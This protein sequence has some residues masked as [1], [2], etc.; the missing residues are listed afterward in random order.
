MS[1]AE[2]LAAAI[3]ALGTPGAWTTERTGERMLGMWPE[4]LARSMRKSAGQCALTGYALGDDAGEAGAG[5]APRYFK[6]ISV[7]AFGLTL[8]GP[9]QGPMSLRVRRR[10]ALCPAAVSGLFA[11]VAVIRMIRSGRAAGFVS[12]RPG[13]GPSGQVKARSSSSTGAPVRRL[14][15]VER[16]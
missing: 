9:P 12:G 1:I 16:V 2:R 10:R 6:I 15:R 5:T 11:L 3:A 4:E 7:A 14:A 13:A 8:A